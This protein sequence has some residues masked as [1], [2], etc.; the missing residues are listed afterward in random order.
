VS[1]CSCT[2]LVQFGRR[3]ADAVLA[4][5]LIGDRDLDTLL[6][7][8]IAAQGGQERDQI[9]A[10]NILAADTGEDVRGKLRGGCWRGVRVPRP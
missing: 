9:G 1:F 3:N 7:E 5:L 10:G 8:G 6:D 2:G 4:G